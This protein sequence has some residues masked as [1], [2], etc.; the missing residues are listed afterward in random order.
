MRAAYPVLLPVAPQ[1][2]QTIVPGTSSEDD[3]RSRSGREQPESGHQWRIQDLDEGLSDPTY[4]GRGL[5]K[6]NAKARTDKRRV[7]F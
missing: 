2:E 3:I 6:Y 7:K 5:S 4:R 1:R